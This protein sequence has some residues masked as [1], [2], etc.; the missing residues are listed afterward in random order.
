MRRIAEPRNKLKSTKALQAAVVRFAGDSGDGIQ[1]TGSQFTDTT[2]L[3]GNDLATCPEYPAEI[4]APAGTLPGVSGYQIHFGSKDVLTP[5]DA[6]DALIAMNPA[7]LVASL[8]DL[9]TNGIVIVN[10]DSFKERDLRKARLSSNPL[11][12]YTL[13][14]FRVFAVAITTLTRRAVEDLKLDGRIVDRCKNFF[15]LGMCYWLY[16][17]PMEPTLRWI[18]DKFAENPQLVEANRRALRAGYSYCD[19]T[20]AFQIQYEVP[21]ARLAPGVY[22]NVSGNTALSLGLI[23]AS[24]RSGAPLFLGSYPIT[25]ASEILHELARHKNFGVITFQAEDEIGAIGAA[26]GAA[27]AG[28][29]AVTTTSGPGMAL[30]A[31]SVGLAVMVELPLVIC[32]IQRGGPSTGLPTKTEQADLFQALFGRHGEAPAPVLAA[33]SP[34]DCFTVAY[35]A[36]RIALKYMVP[37]IVL[38][39]GYLARSTGPW[40]IPELDDLPAIKARY[41]ADPDGFAPYARDPETLARPWAI[42]GTPGLEHRVGGLEKRDVSGVI[43]YDPLNHERMVDLRARKVAAIARE[44]GPVVPKGD[45]DGDL[46]I[47]GWGS[48]KGAIRAAAQARRAGGRRIGHVH[49]RYL[50]P[51]PPNLA[52]VLIRYKRVLVP[53]LNMGQLA[54]LLRSRFLVDAIVF[55]KNQGQPFRQREIEAK[56]EEALR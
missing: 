35:E 21:P 5:G 15:A 24:Q 13:D 17:R 30:N 47:V 23:A 55:G 20:E 26:I 54:W 22:R 7:A 41:R 29:L 51:L 42:P 12:D 49:L 40:R 2:A 19:A 18:G 38:S 48:T 53:E 4:R 28:A 8:S 27:F 36:S 25:P 11:D 39:D 32:N 31:E 43:D 50:N 3:F 52:D 34:G 44:I 9:K 14:R 16:S 10:T 6:V 45:G 33:S 46:L 1:L 37:V 56:I